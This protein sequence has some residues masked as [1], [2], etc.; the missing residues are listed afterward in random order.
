MEE[1][2][3]IKQCL[4]ADPAAQKALYDR[5]AGQVYTVCRRYARDDGE[6][7]D[8]LQETFITVFRKLDTFKFKGSLMGWIRVI[9]MNKALRYIQSSKRSKH[10]DIDEKY[11][12]GTEPK[13]LD[14]LGVEEILKHV[15]NLPDGYREV[16]NLYVLEGLRHGDIA[17]K[18]GIGE[19]TSRSQLTKAR[20]MLQKSINKM[21]YIVL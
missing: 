17:E 6:A 15:Q 8:I 20:K 19:S 18:L 4:N 13:A 14:Q 11:D 7:Q 12:M 2:H 5:Y 21:T 1:R 3:L 10:V 16:F 9:A